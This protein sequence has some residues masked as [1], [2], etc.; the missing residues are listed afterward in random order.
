MTFYRLYLFLLL[1]SFFNHLQAQTPVSEASK[2]D[3][4]EQ[5]DIIEIPNRSAQVVARLNRIEKTMLQQ[6]SLQQL[7]TTSN[8]RLSVIDSVYK[9][10]QVANLD[11]LNRRHLINKRSYWKQRE[12]QIEDIKS[13]LSEELNQINA[14]LEL[15]QNIDKQWRLVAQSLNLDTNDSVVSD[16][17]KH[18]YETKNKVLNRLVE[19]ESSLLELQ[20]QAISK[21][22]KVDN[23]LESITQQINEEEQNIFLHT[24]IVIQ[25]LF[26]K[27]K[28]ISTLDIIKRNLKIETQ[29]L[30]DYMR[31]NRS[32]SVLFILI[33]ISGVIAF[34]WLKKSISKKEE[35]LSDSYYQLSLNKLLRSYRSTAFVI[36]IWLAALIFPNQPQLFK[37]LIRIAICLPLSILLYKLV[38]KRLFVSLMILFAIV[39][40]KIPISFFPSNYTIYQV[41]ILL[42]ALIELIALLNIRSYI[43][44]LSIPNR[45]AALFIN[46]IILAAILAVGILFLPGLLGFTL[47]TELIVNIIIT[48]AF[49]ISLLFVSMVIAIGIIEYLFESI[50]MNQLKVVEVYGQTFK[51]RLVQTIRLVSV[52]TALYIILFSLNIDEEVLS[53]FLEGISHQFAI[54]SFSVSL[55]RIILL[56]FILFLSI[57]T[58]NVIKILL[59]DDVL[60]RTKL[61][62]GLPH[63]IALLAKY[64]MI[65]LGITIAVSIAGIPMTSLTVLIG[66]FGVGIGFGLQNIFNNLVSGL[67]LLFERPIKI[68]DVIEVGQLLGRVKSIGIRSSIIRTFDGAEVIVPNGQLISNEV[69]N[70]THSDP[71]RRHEV[72]VGV[73]YGSDVVKVKRILEEQ[74]HL[75]KDILKDP[76]PSVLFVSMGESSLDFRLLFWISKVKEGVAI[77]SDVTQMIYAA[78]TRE[79]IQIP[80]PQRDIHII[81]QPKN[82]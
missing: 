16:N 32:N 23:L 36:V 70:W 31:D 72:L 3:S 41:I 51:K 48:N 20:N 81:S 82:T 53:F 75:H 8:A 69:I 6:E 7:I 17:V 10:E 29:L 15:V 52:L 28:Y 25:D 79:G 19:Q 60:S 39:L 1:V 76:E 33:L 49:S 4:F 58:S 67:I 54:G 37:D 77:K 73:A 5:I 27:E 61:G 46:R 38:N 24:P 55:G 57:V 40:I 26:E 68:E 66:A 9:L 44:K 64:A 2:V 22:T 42:L 63:T 14:H 47:L 62:Q 13:K 43:L 74:L 65:T 21:Q 80:F 34:H 50:R 30:G 56:I 18:L 11:A 78:L 71:Q 45:L 12:G 35:S 59:E